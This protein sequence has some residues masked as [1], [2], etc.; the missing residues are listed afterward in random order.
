MNAGDVDLAL[1]RLGSKGLDDMTELLDRLRSVLGDRYVISREIG[2]GGMAAVFLGDD[3]KHDRQVAVK[4]LHPE[5]GAAIG[6]DRFLREINIAAHLRH[7]HIV[8]LLDS[9]EADGL[10]YYVMPYVEGESLRQRLTVHGALEISE[11][12]RYWR[13]VVDAIAYA[14]RHGILHRDIKPENVLLADRHA[15]VVDFG[16]G[17]ALRQIGKNDTLTGFGMA[18]GTPAYM[19][20]EQ[21]VASDEI[22]H[23]ADIYALGVLAYEMLTGRVPFASS[24]PTQMVTKL[25]APAPDAREYRPE[26]SAEV[27]RLIKRCLEPEPEKRWQNADE[28]L[29]AVES[30]ATP[31]TGTAAAAWSRVTYSRRQR[32]VV[33]AAVVLMAAALTAFT[34]VSMSRARE[35]RWAQETGVPELKRL[36]DA[37]VNDSAFEIASRVRAAL[38]DDRGLDSL[39]QRVS[40]TAN[41]HTAPE[42][43]RVYWTS[44]RGDTANWHALGETPLENVAVPQPRGF[45]ALLL[46]YEKPGYVTALR[47]LGVELRANT[48]AVLDRETA[49]NVEAVRVRGG[50]I[51]IPN[52]TRLSGDSLRLPD[53]LIDRFEVT[54]KQFKQFVAGGGY[55]RKE[56]WE[57]PMRTSKGE[58]S[59]DDAISRFVDKT[60]R[61]GP[62]TWEGG[63]IPPGKENYPVNGI[64]WYEAQAFAKFAG[65]SLPTIY[66][67]RRAAQSSAS[68][69]MLPRSNIEG[70]GL[71]PVGAFKA[72]TPYGVY[73]MAGNVREWCAN[74]DGVKRYILGGGWSENAYV[75]SD[76]LTADA[77]D[78][79]AINGVRLMQR[80]PVTATSRATDEADAFARPAPRGFRD[81]AAEKPVSDAELRSFLPMFDYDRSPLNAFVEKSDSS[82]SRWIK[83]TIVFDAAYA[84]ER[85]RAYLFLPRSVRAPFQTIVFFPGASIVDARSSKQLVGVPDYVITNGRAVL[86]PIYKDTYERGGV[87]ST[88][89]GTDPVYNMTGGL[90]GPITYRDHVIMYVKD[91]RRSV[92]YLA[93]RADVDTA[94]LAYIGYSWGGRLAAINLAVEHRFKTAVLQLPGLNFAPRRKEVDELNYLPHVYIPTLIL[95]GQ[96]DDVFPLQ[97]AALPFV[98]HL[99]VPATQKRHRIYPTQHFLPRD[100][101]IRETLDWLDRYLGKVSPAR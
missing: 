77:L 22:D 97:T 66:H 2:R 39:W 72:I 65:K 98:E 16:I 15:S 101:V 69:W 24:T 67:W 5:L 20:P 71:A 94:K 41:L 87:E 63:D 56:L 27:A 73:D 96:Y 53:F 76:A 34:W 17:K 31:V 60:G 70:S 42:G 55:R 21:A 4:V 93:T 80:F 92:D 30:L 61:P 25:S 52:A 12:V 84:Q 11:A 74:A 14:H 48:P 79:S 8:P 86:Y 89:M 10:L 38:P 57:Y 100:A 35:R 9:G 1:T 68:S 33:I 36:A 45:A 81:Y 82:D 26:V 99:G 54:N 7:P 40:T 37:F 64:S 23:R 13:D 85:M 50:I 95:S 19:A 28:L 51:A 59:W 32:N 46:K 88:P 58:L 49:R 44:Y 78:R 6:V 29:E 62:A 18:I 43:A 3:R 75:F 83:Q 91:L 90:L 47:P